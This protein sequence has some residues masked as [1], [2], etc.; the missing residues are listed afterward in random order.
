MELVEELPSKER[1][2]M[3]S[4]T[5]S[6]PRIWVSELTSKN[7]V[8]LVTAS[9]AEE[10]FNFCAT[11]GIG[12]SSGG[13]KP[14]SLAFLGSITAIVSPAKRW[15]GDNIPE[16]ILLLKNWPVSLGEVKYEAVIQAVM[17]RVMT[18]KTAELT[19]N[20]TTRDFLKLLF[21]SF[22]SSVIGEDCH[23]VSFVITER[24]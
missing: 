19:R 14:S 18:D 9:T 17:T 12:G 4:R 6:E 15:N 22:E 7:G 23:V 11:K 3:L 8:V 16:A 5:K 24:G 2:L 21:S 20:R 13:M 1:P 10:L